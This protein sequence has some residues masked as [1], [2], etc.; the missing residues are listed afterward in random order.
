MLEIAVFG[1]I[2]VSGMMKKITAVLVAT[3]VILPGLF[4]AD[5]MVIPKLVY[6]PV[7]AIKAVLPEGWSVKEVADN[8]T[9]IGCAEGSG[10]A[11]FL[12]SPRQAA[13]ETKPDFEAAVYI[14]PSDYNDGA[15]GPAAVTEHEK[16][17]IWASPDVA[18]A[19]WA[20][21]KNDILKAILISD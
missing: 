6:R 17:Y 21:I 13:A 10:Y 7:A 1:T 12:A 16:I 9:P 19:G 14:M 18:E 2:M 20:G 4:A 11:V 3:C 8:A 5:I 15:G